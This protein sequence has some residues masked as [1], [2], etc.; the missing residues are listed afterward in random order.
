MNGYWGSSPVVVKHADGKL[1]IFIH[2]AAKDKKTLKHNLQTS[3]GS[4]KWIGWGSLPGSVKFEVESNIVAEQNHDGRLEL[5][6]IGSD[7]ALWHIWQ[8]EGPPVIQ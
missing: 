7:K 1:D 8:I 6:V 2:D 5:F 4:S 3:P